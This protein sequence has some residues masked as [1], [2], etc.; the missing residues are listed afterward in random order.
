MTFKPPEITIIHGT[1]SNAALNIEAIHFYKPKCL[2]CS[3][4]GEAVR[5]DGLAKVDAGVHLIN[6]CLATSGAPD[7]VS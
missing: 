1:Y 5:S 3:W 7:D 4:I 6:G 2:R